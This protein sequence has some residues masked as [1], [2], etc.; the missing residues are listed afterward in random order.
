MSIP[1]LFVGIL[2]KW[3]YSFPGWPFS[4]CGT[5]FPFACDDPPQSIIP[6]IVYLIS[7][8]VVTLRDRTLEDMGAEWSW[9]VPTTC[10]LSP[11]GP[12]P[13]LALSL[14]HLLLHLCLSPVLIPSFLSFFLFSIG[15]FFFN[16]FFFH[17]FVSSFCFSSSTLYRRLMMRAA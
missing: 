1:P 10:L 15:G 11:L 2:A 9:I 17:L 4:T 6:Y 3:K 14:C 12:S 7:G 16:F 5:P 8:P 13:P